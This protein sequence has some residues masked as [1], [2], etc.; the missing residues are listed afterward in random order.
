[1]MH[2]SKIFQSGWRPSK[3][4]E[5]GLARV[6]EVDPVPTADGGVLSSNIP[7]PL[8]AMPLNGWRRCIARMGIS[9]W[10]RLL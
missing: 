10:D 1:M 5:H 3:E 4:T 9:R 6:Y 2:H 7:M 8:S